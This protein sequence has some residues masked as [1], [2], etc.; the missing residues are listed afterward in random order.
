[1]LRICFFGAA[2]DTRN[3]GVDALCYA[4]LRGLARAAPDARVTVFDHGRGLRRA[5]A[6]FDTGPLDFERCGAYLTRRLYRRESLAQVRLAARA[7]WLGGLTNPA[8]RRLLESDAVL[9]ITGGDSFT[10]LY[11]PCRFAAAVA[12][13]RLALDLGKPLILLPQTYGPYRDPQVRRIAADIVR[14]ATQAWARDTRSFETLRELAGAAFDPARHRCGVDV[15]FAL[16]PRPP[17]RPLPEPL[18]SWF[19]E[20]ATRNSQLATPAPQLA[21]R[22]SQLATSPSV[23]TL[24][25]RNS[26]LATSSPSAPQLETRNSQLETPLIG[27]NISGLIWHDPL[28]MRQRYG[29]KAEY[30]EV[31]VGFLRRLLAQTDAR[32]VLV[33]HVLSPPGHYE[34]D[35]AA[36]EQVLAALRADADPAVTRAVADRVAAAPPLYDQP[37]EMKWLIARCDWFCGTRMHACIAGL[38]SGVPTAAIAYSLKTQGVF[39]TCGQ[40]AAVADPRVQGTEETIDQLWRTF[41]ARDAV[42]DDLRL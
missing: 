7:G 28:A 32:V 23:P 20:L 15:A 25:T 14:R 41:T 37:S 13:K 4:V 11:G 16:E 39:E 33:P 34:S 29:F 35:P 9:D 5:T 19:S 17:R 27:F 21:T 24:E 40:G 42:L 22:Y 10:D 31:I 38:S 12:T 36:N 26:S 6:A 30:R 3:L 18:V 8:A 2:P 1:M